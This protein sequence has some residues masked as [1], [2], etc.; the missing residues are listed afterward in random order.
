M[1]KS[2]DFYSFNRN[3]TYLLKEKLKAVVSLPAWGSRAWVSRL[4]QI[5]TISVPPVKLQ[6]ISRMCN[7]WENK[8]YVTK[9]QIQSL[10]GSLLHVTKCVKSS[11]SFLNRMLQTLR[12][13]TNSSHVTLD[14]DFY[15]AL[16]T[17]LLLV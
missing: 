10:L 17:L 12:N 7:Q 6:K 11:H 1:T 3:K 2:L 8:K 16:T 14:P 5:G 13:S 15:R 9:K 4:T